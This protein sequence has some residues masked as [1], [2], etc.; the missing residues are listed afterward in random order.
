M[1]L[2]E[3]RGEPAAGGDQIS[4]EI[5]RMSATPAPQINPES[6]RRT[7]GTSQDKLCLLPLGAWEEGKD[8]C[9]VPPAHLT[10]SVEWKITMSMANRRNK[11]TLAMDTEQDVPLEL[12]PYWR[13]SLY[14]KLKRLLKKKFAADSQ[15]KF[16]DTFAVVSVNDRS[17]RDLRKHFDGLKVNWAKIE[18]QLLKWGEHCRRGR[19][20]RINLEFHCVEVNRPRAESASATSRGGRRSAT[21][22]MLTE[23]DDETERD[24]LNGNRAVW[25]DVYALMR[26]PGPPCHL[27]PH[28]WREPVGKKHYRM[29]THQLKQLVLYKEEGNKLESH[30]DVPDQVRQELFAVEQQRLERQQQ[31]AKQ[32]S[33]ALPPIHITNV[34]PGHVSDQASD[35]SGTNVAF[36]A[37]LAPEQTTCVKI[38]GQRD[39]AVHKYTAWQRSQV[40]NADLKSQFDQAESAILKHGWD[41]EQVYQT[42]NVAV[43]TNEGVMEGIAQR[44]VRD[45]AEWAKQ[46]SADAV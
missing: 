26:C 9:T 40:H 30:D 14:P 35:S 11:R 21:T 15:P 46:Q 3:T 23:L 16:E 20:L 12:V 10:Y 28:C 19:N 41:L 42:K 33:K 43:M 5:G 34:L 31:S 1:D 37:T 18:D 45:I 39:I 22:R 8:Y 32:S 13:H 4:T 17:E 2:S 24:R 6:T 38:V 25:R 7:P 44:Y 27:G 36:A 29:L